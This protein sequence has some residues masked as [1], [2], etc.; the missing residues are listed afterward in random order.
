MQERKGPDLAGCRATSGLARKV[1]RDEAVKRD[2]RL[3]YHTVRCASR[4]TC[5]AISSHRGTSTV[6]PWCPG[7]VIGGF[8][9]ILGRG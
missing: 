6:V 4:G 5:R 9:G 2:Q 8:L 3:A 7:G 1:T